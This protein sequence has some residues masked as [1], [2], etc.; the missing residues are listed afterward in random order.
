MSD[1]EE[2]GSPGVLFQE[3]PME[4]LRAKDINISLKRLEYVDGMTRNSGIHK[5]QDVESMVQR[6]NSEQI[7][8]ISIRKRFGRLMMHNGDE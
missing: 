7:P 2:L 3:N 5:G 4:A 6:S 1:V 8:P